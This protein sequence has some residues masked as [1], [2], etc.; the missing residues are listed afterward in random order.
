MKP[1]QSLKVQH[2]EQQSIVSAEPQEKVG[3]KDEFSKL[4][5]T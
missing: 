3:T 2:F 1:Q 5:V 4:I